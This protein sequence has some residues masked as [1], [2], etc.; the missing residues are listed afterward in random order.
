M[1]DATDDE[2]PPYWRVHPREVGR[3]LV[4]VRCGKCGRL[5]GRLACD[6][7]W[8]LEPAD[9]PGS[10]AYM[11]HADARAD[12]DRDDRRKPKISRLSGVYRDTVRLRCHKRCGA[13]WRI[14]EYGLTGAMLAAREAG[15]REVE[16]GVD[17]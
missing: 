2:R 15:R 11:N 4:T 7:A 8:L 16:L 12:R 14:S 5:I 9:A 10:L 3:R 6:D 1:A 13:D 17:I